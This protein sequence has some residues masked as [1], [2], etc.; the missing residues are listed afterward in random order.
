MNNKVLY[1]KMLGD[2]SLSC[3]DVTLKSDDGRSKKIWHLLAYLLFYRNRISPSDELIRV[4]WG[5]DAN[6]NPASALKTTLYRARKMLLPIQEQIGQELIISIA[7][8]YRINPA[9]DVC[10]DCESFENACRYDRTS[11][12]WVERGKE[13]LNSYTGA[14]LGKYSGEMWVIPLGVYYE[15]M[16]QTLLLEVLAKLWEDE[17]YSDLVYH[18]KRSLEYIHNHEGVYQYLMRGLLKIGEHAL[19]AEIYEE[20]RRALLDNFGVTPDETSQSLYREILYNINL[21]SLSDDVILT[22]LREND[23][24]SGAMVCEY[25]IFRQ[26]CHAESRASI[27]SGQ[28]THVALLSISGKNGKELS[29][30][31]LSVAAENLKNTVQKRLRCGDVIS[32]CSASQIIIMLRSAGYEDS[33]TVCRRLID[34]F[35]KAYPHT[36]VSVKFSVLVLLADK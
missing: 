33:K 13:G 17:H 32:Q 18:A 3:G 36:P 28:N 19:A 20:M 35:V 24:L 34:A 6:D 10:S 15:N 4:L 21:Q 26:L 12:D 8:G 22:Q 23:M 7:G 30:R 14:F 5:N 29:A 25:P 31:S 16:Y 2:F 1:V 27:R 9:V 11:N